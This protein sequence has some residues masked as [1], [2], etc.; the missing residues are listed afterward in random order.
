MMKDL[1]TTLDVTDDISGVTLAEKSFLW[2]R[3]GVD[4]R[5][6][7]GTREADERIWR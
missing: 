7:L 4:G 1:S 6:Q 5:Q 2:R 3:R